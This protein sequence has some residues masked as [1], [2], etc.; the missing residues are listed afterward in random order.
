METGR[1][2][3]RNKR[4]GSTDLGAFSEALAPLVAFGGAARHLLLHLLFLPLRRVT[5]L[6]IGRV[7]R[8]TRAELIKLR[9]HR[10]VLIGA[11]L[12]VIAAIVGALLGP[13]L[14]PGRPN[15]F[16]AFSYGLQTG[17]FVAAFILLTSGANTLAAEFH[18]G[19]A[20]LMLS[21]P[22]H[23][24]EVVLGKAIIAWLAKFARAAGAAERSPST[25]PGTSW[26]EARSSDIAL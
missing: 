7:L 17:A 10:S 14:S 12:V 24:S 16:L 11:G 19:T 6:R 4:A 18:A 5:F 13:P 3:R 9:G 1:R 15:F 25:C 22:V 23:R 26:G 21:R 2:R 20:R 8:L